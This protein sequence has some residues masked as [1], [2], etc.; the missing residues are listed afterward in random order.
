MYSGSPFLPQDITRI[1]KNIIKKLKTLAQNELKQE[2]DVQIRH[3]YPPVWNW[4]ASK[5]TKVTICVSPHHKHQQ[6][7]P[8]LPHSLLG[9]D[10]QL[11]E[12]HVL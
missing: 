2:A 4:P 8:L 6:L 5:K 12:F 1:D 3:S 10:A 9:A 7:L 11:L